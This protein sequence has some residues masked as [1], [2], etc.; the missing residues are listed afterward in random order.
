[1]SGP[2]ARDGSSEDDVEMYAAPAPR[3]APAPAA[4]FDGAHLAATPSL[5]ARSAEDRIG[6]ASA[7]ACVT[8]PT[9]PGSL[10]RST[11][12]PS[13]A[14]AA[15]R[16]ASGMHARMAAPAA[17]LEEDS[18]EDSEYS[19]AEAVERCTA[20]APHFTNRFPEVGGS[21]AP[22]ASFG[23]APPTATATTLLEARSAEDRIGDASTRACVVAPS[24]SRSFGQH[25]SG[26]PQPA[27]GLIAG[28]AT[29][30]TEGAGARSVAPLKPNMPRVNTQGHGAD[31]MR[32]QRSSSAAALL[33]H[34]KVT[35]LPQDSE[36]SC[37]E[38]SDDDHQTRQVAR[39]G[40]RTAMMEPAA[41]D[42]ARAMIHSADV[43]KVPPTAAADHIKVRSQTRC[44]LGAATQVNRQRPDQVIASATTEKQ[45]ALA[46]QAALISPRAQR[47][48]HSL[49][50]R[51]NQD[52]ISGDPAR[53]R[54]AKADVGASPLAMAPLDSHV[55]VSTQELVV[56]K[57]FS[58][59][60]VRR[61]AG[62]GSKSKRTREEAWA[63][64]YFSDD[65]RSPVRG[66]GWKL[67]RRRDGAS[68]DEDED[69]DDF[70]RSGHPEADTTEHPIERLRQATQSDHPVVTQQLIS[71]LEPPQASPE[72][73]KRRRRAGSD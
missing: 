40:G 7:R 28:A 22:S 11:N 23:R 50:V 39:V 33:G 63:T 9:V 17:R 43:R 25:K 61:R 5:G 24:A 20:P 49:A 59:K 30:S 18:G 31:R 37:D 72:R 70:L 55:D 21:V 35:A 10:G 34:H 51:T 67:P 52:S 4:S 16:V 46:R 38:D 29:R 73:S 64:G 45:T 53:G 60:T 69:E 8:A 54:R 6:R 66:E 13:D 44:A 62:H 26:A 14:A 1:M 27:E 48:S 56:L 3:L 32:T 42:E 36:H 58:R 47:A 65:G 71:M 12:R 15:A 57:T 19:D 68:E 41:C 2:A